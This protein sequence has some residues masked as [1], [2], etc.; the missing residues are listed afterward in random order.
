MSQQLP[1]GK[2]IADYSIN[3]DG[4][5]V[6]TAAI[7]TADEKGIIKVDGVG[8]PVVEQIGNQQADFR[9]GIT[10]NLRIN[11]FTF[12]MLWDWKQGGDIYNRNTQWNTISE[13]SAIVD[14]AG[15]PENEKKT[16]KYYG[17]LYDVNQNQGFW[18][19]D[20]TFL[21]LREVSLTYNFPKSFSN[22]L[23]FTSGRLSLIG[24]NVLQFT[25]YS[26]WDTE[27]SSYD[28]G[29]QQNFAVD[30]S[31]YPTQATYSLSLNLK[32]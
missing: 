26:G 5:V 22:S 30:Y 10:S 8:T 15:K 19:E 17:S 6:Q 7:G 1:A 18:V 29:V 28:S 2:T 25:N 4:L 3:S 27:V 21:K 9:V 13:R 12:Y 32:F 23:P 24:R 31:V 11:D 14:Q 20:G 16:R